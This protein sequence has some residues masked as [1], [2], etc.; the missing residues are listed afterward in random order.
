MND[1]KYYRI[2]IFLAFGILLIPIVQSRFKMISEKPLSGAVQLAPDTTFNFKGWFSGDYSVLKEKYLNDNFGFRNT[3]VRFRNQFYYSCFNKVFAQDVICGKYGY[4]Y[5][6]KYLQAHAGMDYLGEDKI[7]ETYRKLKFIQDTLAKKGI[8]FIVIFAPGKATYFSEYIPSPF[9]TNIVETNY[10]KNVEWAKK[11]GVRFIDFNSLFLQLK[12]KS[13]Y[14]LYP[15]TGTHWSI[16]GIHLAFDSINN[17]LSNALNKPIS[18]FDYSDVEISDSL[19][20]PDGDIA[21]GLNLFEEVPHYKMAYPRIKWLD[22]VNVFKPRVFTISDSYWM[23]AYFLGLPQNT[24]L[25]HKFWYYYQQVLGFNIPDYGKDP[26]D[27]D[28]KESIESSDVIMIMSTEA[29]LK[30]IGWGFINDIYNIYSNGPDYYQIFIANRKKQYYITKYIIN[31]RNND[32]WYK[33]IKLQAYDLNISIDSCLLLNA[34]YMY[35]I[36][37]K[38]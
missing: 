5:E 2:L 3:F 37:N 4:L 27:Y 21:Y 1:K 35:N 18:K 29:T 26:N 16:Y 30:Q 28:L 6:L 15:K 8:L 12:P 22:T 24:Y 32:D 23:A 20:S 13:K 34:E 25:N 9:N 7:K 10:F 38:K 14:P 17:Y 19:R 36:Y 33:K 31:I 11:T